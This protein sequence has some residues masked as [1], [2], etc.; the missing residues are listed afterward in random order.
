M[1]RAAAIAI[2]VAIVWGLHLPNADWVPMAAFVTMK[3]SLGQATLRAEQRIAGTL[4]GALVA[5]VFLLTVSNT[6]A[7]EVVIILA[8]ALAA[9]FH[10]ANYAIYA[11]GLVTAVLIGMDVPN[12]SNLAAQGERVLATFVGVGI[13]VGVLLLSD[14]IQKHAAKT[15]P[16]AP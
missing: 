11:V 3:T 4:I 2:P 8:A 7:L 12:P 10:D 9:T 5:T 1:S 16:A 15:V 6:H 13:G 14:L